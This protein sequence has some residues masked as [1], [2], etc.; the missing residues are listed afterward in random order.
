MPEV[1]FAEPIVHTVGDVENDEYAEAYLNFG[2]VEE[3]GDRPAHSPI[4]PEASGYLP[5]CFTSWNQLDEYLID[6]REKGF[7]VRSIVSR[8]KPSNFDVLT[9][10]NWGVIVALNRWQHKDDKGPYKCLKVRWLADAKE[11]LESPEQLFVI[12]QC[13]GWNVLSDTLTRQRT[14]QIR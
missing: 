14:G 7:V 13:D 9:C 12:Y 5:P 4:A 8:W 1:K 2:G 6:V 11:T 10:E 3:I